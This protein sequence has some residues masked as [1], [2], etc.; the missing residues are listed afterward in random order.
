MSNTDEEF[1]N[2]D[3]SMPKL[4]IGKWITYLFLTFILALVLYFPFLMTVESLIKS[5]LTQI[6]GCPITVDEVKFELFSPKV[7][8]PKTSVPQRCIGQAGSPITIKQTILGFRGFT[9]SPFGP[10]FKLD[11]NIASNNISALVTLGFSS[12]Q[13]NI[14]DNV[15]DLEKIREIFNS[16]K[17]NG[18]VRVNSV[19]TLKNNQLDD[20]KLTLN[21]S[22][23]GLAPQNLS[24]FKLFGLQIKKL[25]LIANMQKG[26]I[27]IKNFVAGDQLSP[28]RANF[29][30]SITPNERQMARSLSSING[31]IAFSK[32][33]IK[34]Y[35]FIEVIMG[36]FNKKDNFYQLEINGPLNSLNFNSPRK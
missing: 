11:T 12:T 10:H 5:S 16:V 4:G 36:R 27:N 7:I 2:V 34:R 17:L 28:I 6:P 23:F 24:G 8:L 33:F 13:I 19:I 14:N 26:K 9:F 20:L 25:A 32:D 29:K 18:K 35:A 21:S 30:G 1:E 3:Y 22:D 31:E 15:L